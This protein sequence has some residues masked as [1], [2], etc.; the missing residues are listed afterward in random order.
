MFFM[1]LYSLFR[2]VRVTVESCSLLFDYKL[3]S[4][5]LT[6]KTKLIDLYTSRYL[7]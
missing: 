2:V 3:L 7:L 5:L 1:E 6:R 4:I